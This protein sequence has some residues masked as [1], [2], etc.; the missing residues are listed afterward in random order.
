MIIDNVK[1]T[2]L[3]EKVGGKFKLAV[4]IQKRIR[5]LMNGSRA[6]IEDAQGM[7]YMEIAIAEI[8][9][10]KIKLEVNTGAPEKPTF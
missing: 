6:L 3:Y 7:T 1:G 10:D 5:E 9:Q 8:M 2:E 4:L